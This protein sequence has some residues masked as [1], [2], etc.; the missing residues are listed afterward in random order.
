[1]KLKLILFL[2]TIFCSMQSMKRLAEA[3][4]GESSRSTSKMR[5]EK[6][7]K[8]LTL[9]LFEAIDS[10]NTKEALE[11][12]ANPAVDPNMRKE[13]AF[14][15]EEYEGEY[16]EEEGAEDEDPTPLTNAISLKLSEIALALI[17]H[18]TIDINLSYMGGGPLIRAIDNSL[19]DV[20]Q[21]LLE[22]PN[23]DL[24][25][26][27]ICNEDTGKSISITPLMVAAEKGSTELVNQ[28]LKMGS[29]VNAVDGD[30]KTAL[31][32]AA[33]AGRVNNI[34]A[35]ASNPG[36]HINSQNSSSDCEDYINWTALM[37]VAADSQNSNGLRA[38]TRLKGIDLDLRDGDGLTALELSIEGD[39]EESVEILL[40]AG[41]NIDFKLLQQAYDNE[42]C[43]HL[44]KKFGGLYIRKN[45]I[46]NGK[47]FT[48]ETLKFIRNYPDAIS[49]PQFKVSRTNLLSALNKRALGI[50]KDLRRL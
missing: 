8:K 45:I 28:L 6:N 46:Q 36:I 30:G 11:L 26:S 22:H 20:T 23:I 5:L 43:Q 4:E 49:G 17:D 21:K 15:E 29:D 32:C 7:S 16:E 10:K 1:M 18:P 25:P 13:A 24:N 47:E 40:E 3:A 31:T 35:L 39:F 14:W 42:D 19:N 50:S 41:A 34:K 38:L 37:H 33:M 48:R 27:I 44:Y 12:I 2:T 9:K